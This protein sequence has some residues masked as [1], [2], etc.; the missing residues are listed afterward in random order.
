V[1]VEHRPVE[2]QPVGDR[3]AGEVGIGS[4]DVAVVAAEQ[5]GPVVKEALVLARLQDDG[6]AR[7]SRTRT[8]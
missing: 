7:L 6:R 2:H 5:P 1:L 8:R 3:E 4:G